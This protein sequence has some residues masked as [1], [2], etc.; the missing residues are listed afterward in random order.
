MLITVVVE[1]ELSEAVAGR[2]IGDYI[3]QGIILEAAGL[4]GIGSVKAKIPGMN[5]RAYY[6]GPVFVIADL[7]NPEKCPLSLVQE[8]IFGLEVAPAMLLRIAVPEIE[9]WILADCEGIAQWLEIAASVVPRYPE[10]V[11]DPKRTLV[12]LAARSHNRALRE[13]I[14]PFRVLGTNR[15]GPNYNEAVGEFVAQRWNPEAARRSAPSL[16]RAITRIAGL[17]DS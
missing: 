14:A 17:A 13:A 1:D 8:L 10:S 7:D 2:L 3:P 6:V 9:S 16:D 11:Q 4:N 12:Q 5:Q 15:T